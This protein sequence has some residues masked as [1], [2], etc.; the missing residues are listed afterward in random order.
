MNGETHPDEQGEL[1]DLPDGVLRHL[2]AHLE[3][4]EDL[5]DGRA[6]SPLALLERSL[7]RVDLL[8]QPLRVLLLVDLRTLA[9]RARK[10]DTFLEAGRAGRQA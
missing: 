5:L 9:H 10:L 2:F 6:L 3:L 4:L 8:L 7:E 1:V